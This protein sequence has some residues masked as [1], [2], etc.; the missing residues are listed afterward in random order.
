M[1]SHG[2]AHVRC[3]NAAIASLVPFVEHERYRPGGWG[4]RDGPLAVFLPPGG[5][6]PTLSPGGAT[7]LLHPRSASQRHRR[8][9]D[10]REPR[11][12]HRL[13]SDDSRARRAVGGSGGCGR[14]GPG[15]ERRRTPPRRGRVLPRRPRQPAARPGRAERH[16]PV[17]TDRHRC[18]RGCRA[19]WAC[20]PTLPPWPSGTSAFAS[21]GPAASGPE[22]PAP[23]CDD[24]A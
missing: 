14:W 12:S 6:Q 18:R 3:V 1:C 2:H 23:P 21:C 16:A 8:T 20:R 5:T 22:Q 7:P 17:T 19:A 15:T 11:P 10:A 24:V 13:R 9:D 4:A